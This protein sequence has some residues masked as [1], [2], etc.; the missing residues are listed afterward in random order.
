VGRALFT[1]GTSVSLGA[2]H[3]GALRGG[4]ALPTAG[5]GY[6]IPPSWQA[7]GMWWGTDELVAAVERAAQRVAAEYPGSMLGVGDLSQRGGG[8]V[9]LHKS[10]ESGRDADLIFYAI[11]ADGTT[12][13]PPDTMPRYCTRRLRNCTPYE[14]AQ[15][16]VTPR[17]FDLQR[18]WA[19]VRALVTDRAVDVGYLFIAERLRDRL[20]SYARSVGEAED[21]VRRAAMVLRPPGHRALP[22]DDHL[23]L[24]IRCSPADRAQ[25]CVDEG[26]VRLRSE[27]VRAPVAR[28]DAP[29]VRRVV[30]AR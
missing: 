1:D 15:A 26:Y 8:G 6:V 9:P 3:R 17:Y 23:H 24:R 21:V 20:L 14:G 29:R 19:L 22:H 7:R 10:H 2:A 4:R 27:L 28:L 16:V 11:D 25:G 12:L 5:E 30:A 18:N 13:A